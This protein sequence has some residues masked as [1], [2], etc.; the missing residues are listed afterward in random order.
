MNNIVIPMQELNPKK[1]KPSLDQALQFRVPIDA[2]LDT[3]IVV[4]IAEPE[5]EKTGGIYVPEHIKDQMALNEN[6]LVK[7]LVKSVG[8]NKEGRKPVVNVNDIVYVYPGGYGAKI[9]IDEVEYLV[10][11][12]RD[13]VAKVK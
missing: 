3:V 1:K 6:L 4:H 7:G 9:I 11:A 5:K 12:E 10:Y 13:M 8:T 2:L